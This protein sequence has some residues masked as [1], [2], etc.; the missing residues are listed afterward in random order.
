MYFQSNQEFYVTLFSNSSMQINP[1]N[2]LSSFTNL[3]KETIF[4]TDD[5]VVGISE[6]YINGLQLKNKKRK[7][8]D[9]IHDPLEY[10]PLTMHDLMHAKLKANEK[11]KNAEYATKNL[12]KKTA[13][14]VPK[15]TTESG[16]QLNYQTGNENISET[17]KL[18]SNSENINLD[19]K[20]LLNNKNQKEVN[21]FVGAIPSIALLFQPL[22]AVVQD[23][24][25][26]IQ[27]NNTIP[28]IIKGFAFIY[29]DIIKPRLIGNQCNRCLR[30]IPRTNV[31]QHIVFKNVEYYPV[32]TNVIQSISILIIDDQGEKMNFSSSSIPTMC[33]L[34]FKK[35]IN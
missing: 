1:N 20:L 27:E 21:E 12:S 2:V 17:P 35:A 8:R 5:W 15:I 7:A 32:Q 19:E 10:K 26:V 14:S 3:L 24:F 6:I 4:L 9:V 29:C 23:I 30:I 25:D 33:T 34:H 18:S 22:T 31:P 13:E 28:K 11:K 16:I